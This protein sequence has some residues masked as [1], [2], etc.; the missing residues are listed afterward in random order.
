VEK[1]KKLNGIATLI[2]VTIGR[3]VQF[4]TFFKIP[5]HCEIPALTVEWQCLYGP[6]GTCNCNLD[7]SKECV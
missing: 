3:Y 5:L 2:L 4:C 6:F 7:I 1:I